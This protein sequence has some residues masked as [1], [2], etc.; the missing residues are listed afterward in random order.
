MRSYKSYDTICFKREVAQLPLHEIYS[1]HDVNSKL[2]L[3]NELF[4]NTLNR[5]APMKYIKIKGRPHKFIGKEIKQLM[6]VRDRRLKSFRKSK[7]SED[8][9]SYKQLRN[10][11]KISIRKAEICS[12]IEKNKDNS[13]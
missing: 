2:D 7:N 11:A 13:K 12:Q 9:N 10:T 1:T 6:K 4:L 8:W 3:F 5:H